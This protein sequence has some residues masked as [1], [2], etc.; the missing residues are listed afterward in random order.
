MPKNKSVCQRKQLTGNITNSIMEKWRKQGCFV[1][2]IDGNTLNCNV[3][4]LAWTQMKE[5]ME[6]FDDWTVDWDLHLTEEEIALVKTPEWRAGLRFT[7]VK[8]SAN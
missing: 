5:A 4:N 3:T 1:R 8:S 2:F 6:H 7:P